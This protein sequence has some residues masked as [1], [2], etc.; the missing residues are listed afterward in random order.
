[1]VLRRHVRQPQLHQRWR[2]LQPNRPLTKRL[3]SCRGVNSVLSKRLPRLTRHPPR[4]R[5]RTRKQ[6]APPQDVQVATEFGPNGK[7]GHIDEN[8]RKSRKICEGIAPSR[9]GW[10]AESWT[11]T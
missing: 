4:C 2:P 8:L 3:P 9:G 1:M 10:T 6:R 5:R 7:K 11:V